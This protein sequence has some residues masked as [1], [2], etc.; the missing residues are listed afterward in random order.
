[1]TV[2]RDT[3]FLAAG[4]A[5]ERIRYAVQETNRVVS[6][7]VY[8]CRIALAVCFLFCSMPFGFIGFCGLSVVGLESWYFY[9]VFAALGLLAFACGWAMLHGQVIIDQHGITKIV[10]FRVERRFAWEDCQGWIVSKLNI[11]SEK[12]QKV[13]VS[14][15]PETPPEMRPVLLD[16]DSFRFRAA[17]FRVHGQRWPIVVYDTE[18]WRP[19]FDAFLGDVR[20]YIGQKEVVAT[21]DQ[22]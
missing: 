18:A 11:S 10:W 5:R 16:G 3:A 4:P 12:E 21:W 17:L 13:W 19:S 7:K 1:M 15:Y 20:A 2:F 22:T 14:L 8:R 9:G 6:Q